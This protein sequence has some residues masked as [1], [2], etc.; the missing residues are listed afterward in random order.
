MEYHESS[1]Q[2][3][4]S[5]YKRHFLP[6]IHADV[7]YGFILEKKFQEHSELEAFIEAQINGINRSDACSIVGAIHKIFTQLLR[8]FATSMKYDDMVGLAAQVIK[9][10][11]IDLNICSGGLGVYQG[12]PMHFVFI[13]MLECALSLPPCGLTE[14]VKIHLS[15][16][17]VTPDEINRLRIGN[18]HIHTIQECWDLYNIMKFAGANLDIK[19]SLRWSV[20]D[21]RRICWVF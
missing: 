11:Q 18:L 16:L 5:G 19:D 1:Q 12:T 14:R 10:Y 17:Q 2:S 7:D 13:N 9:L 20:N 3:S 8:C 21:W 4:K 15:K 6:S